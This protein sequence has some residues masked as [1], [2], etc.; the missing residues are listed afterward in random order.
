M[1]GVQVFRYQPSGYRLLEQKPSKSGTSASSNLTQWSACYA[2]LA[3][4]PSLV[5][6]QLLTNRGLVAHIKTPISPVRYSR[7]T[8]LSIDQSSQVEMDNDLIAQVFPYN[9]KPGGPTFALDAILDSANTSRF[10]GPRLSFPQPKPR[11]SRCSRSPTAEPTEEGND[12]DGLGYSPHLELRFSHGPRTGTGFIF[13]T[14]PDTCDVFLPAV[15]GISQHHFALT[16]ENN[17]ADS[18]EYRLVLRDFSTFGSAVTYDGHG[19]H[20]RRNFRWILNGHETLTR[21]TNIVIEICAKLKLLIR[22]PYPESLVCRDK[23]SQFLQGTAGPEALFGALDVLNHPD[24]EPPSG[25]RTPGTGP[26][27]IRHRELGQG[28]YGVVTHLWDVSSAA[29]YALKEPTKR[30]IEEK[31]VNIKN[32][33]REAKLLGRV[34]HVSCRPPPKISRD[35]ATV[36]RIKPSGVRIKWTDSQA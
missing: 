8:I 6:E 23:I 10:V 27:L 7:A 9:D 25:S 36:V 15:Q 31:K 1:S 33:M 12:D 14:D 30:A 20:F 17:F 21:N 34:S 4:Q 2:C 16:F 5:W 3:G 13:G 28:S 19:R 29:Q 11:R 35:R 18:A 24:T 26:I 32:W 22:I